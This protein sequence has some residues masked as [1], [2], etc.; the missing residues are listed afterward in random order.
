MSRRSLR[1]TLLVGAAL[2]LARP[3]V[4]QT[5]TPERAALLDS[6]VAALL[7]TAVL[8]SFSISVARDGRIVFARAY[9]WADLEHRVPADTTTRYRIGS[10]SKMVTATAVAR[11]VQ[12]GALDLDAPLSSLVP[13]FP[14]ADGITPR[15][16]A[17]HL[18]GIGHYQ[19][20]DRIDRRHQYA[21]VEEALGTFARSPRVGRPGERYAY[22]TH[23][24]TLLSRA[25]EAAAGVPF[26][27][28]LANDVFGPLGMAHSGP[29]MRSDPPASMATLYYRRGREAI[30][31]AQPENP[32][33]KW[34]G[35]GLLS[36]PTDLVRMGSGYLQGFIDPAVREEL[37]T[38]QRTAS[39]EPTGVAVGW[40]IGEDFEGR[41]VVHHAGAMGGARSVLVIYPDD[42]AV[43]ATTTNT[44]WVSSVE[45]NAQVLLEALLRAEP[46]GIGRV[47]AATVGTLDTVSA[48][49]SVRID[50]ATGWVSTPPAL[51]QL[52]G[53]AS[54][55]SLRIFR[56][57]GELWAA[58]TPF[59]AGALRLGV[60]A[61]SVRGELSLGS[62]RWRFAGRRQP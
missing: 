53:Q 26:L 41:R 20:E 38:V 23:G 2:A 55:D 28:Y 13:S 30:P 62:R 34:A 27:Q 44:A 21:S 58:V 14:D 57:H 35:G 10:V 16:L 11:L 60:S 25:A 56:L 43:V 8:P 4:A 59:G 39:G 37:W 52:F 42:G 22:S 40:R 15:L 45:R 7:E 32:S 50:G 31:I 12:A 19:R 47:T 54:V 3:G 24:Y 5:V 18:A 33:Y 48:N 6:V 49:G 46:G 51:A 9:G 61:D 29:E 36:T 1:P 17:G